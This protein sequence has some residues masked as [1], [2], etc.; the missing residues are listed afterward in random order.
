MRQ[1]INRFRDRLREPSLILL[2]A[3]QCV[4]IFA[5][6]PLLSFGID[7]PSRFSTAVFSLIV[8]FVVVP[9]R[10]RRSTILAVVALAL[11]AAAAII[12]SFYETDL[13]DGL[14]AVGAILALVTVTWVVAQTVFAPGRMSANRVVGAIIIY[15]NFAIMFSSLYRFIAERVPGAFV[16]IPFHF[17]RT[18]SVGDLMYFSMLTLTTV[19]YGDITPVYPFARS[20]SNLEAIVGQLYPAII[21]A[22]IVTLYSPKAPHEK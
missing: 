8:L 15:L 2:L 14:G 21:L 11:A 22:R 17:E 7:I 1:R 9:S 18:T 5:L 6:G 19:G 16:G 20:L 3:I 12:R 4:L 13:T 10:D